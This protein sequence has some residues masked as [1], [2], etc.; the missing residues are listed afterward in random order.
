MALCIE[1]VFQVHVYQYITEKGRKVFQFFEWINVYLAW[2]RHASLTCLRQMFSLSEL[3]LSS[4]GLFNHGG[5]SN[6]NM[7]LQPDVMKQS[8]ERPLI[9]SEW[10]HF[11]AARG[12]LAN[13]W[14]ARILF[15]FYIAPGYQISELCSLKGGTFHI[16]IMLVLFELWKLLFPLAR[17]VKTWAS[18]SSPLHHPFGLQ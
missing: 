9:S 15:L 16:F 17:S 3:Q 18:L 12:V 7:A 14:S 6:E 1:T 5:K 13:V 2:W 4:L 11:L 10:K 8:V